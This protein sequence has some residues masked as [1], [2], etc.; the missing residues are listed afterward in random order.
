MTLGK[1]GRANLLVMG[2]GFH[3]SQVSIMWLG[4]STGSSLVAAGAN[5]VLCLI[6]APRGPLED[7]LETLR[8][9]LWTLEHC[10]IDSGS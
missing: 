1:A 4:P 3:H 2:I 7:P 10:H 9:R 8:A 5:E 6:S